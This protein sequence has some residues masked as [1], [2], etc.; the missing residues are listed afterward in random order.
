[1]WNAPP[2]DLMEHLGPLLAR[3][4]GTLALACHHLE[5]GERW[6]LNDIPMPSASLIKVPLAI[7]AYRAA[8]RGE[9]ALNERVEVPPLAAD[10]EADFD[11]LGLA[12]PGTRFSW[13]KI[14]DRMLTESDNAA[15]NTVIARL[16][17]GAIAPLIAELGLEHTV[18]QRPMLDT[19]ARAGGRE[20]ITTPRE[21][22]LLLDGLFAGRLLDA[23][24]TAAM[25]GLLGQQR[26]KDKLARG[27]PADW[28]FAHKTGELSGYRHDAGL[29][30]SPVAGE[31]GWLVAAMAAGDGPVAEAILPLVGTLLAAY[32]TSRR[33]R[34][35]AAT[36]WLDAARDRQAR[37]PRHTWDSLRVEWR[38]GDV[39][40]AG[41]SNWGQAL[42]LAPATILRCDRGP[43]GEAAVASVACLQLRR[44][45]GHAHELVSQLRLGDPLTVL[46]KGPDWTL[47]QGPD[48]Y[49]AYAKTNNMVPAVAWTPTHVVAA[50]L[51][52]IETAAGTTL[53]LSGGTR[54][55]PGAWPGQWR[56]PSGDAIPLA[57]DL[58]TPIGAKGT[59]QAVLAFARQCLG[60]PYLWGGTTGWGIDCSGLVQLAYFVQGVSLPRD[61]DQQQAATEPVADRADLLA[62][63]L[64]FF[65][66]HVGLY[67]G[68]RAYLHASAQAGCVTIG[69]FDPSSPWWDPV[70]DER[71]DGGG[72]SP[73]AIAWA[74]I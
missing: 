67:L 40:V 57:P 68:D 28:P 2:P 53:Q 63:D 43:T 18:L 62:G 50:P 21:M 29:V 26:S 71:Y 11:N 31:R 58:T 1:M 14:I 65:P 46:E 7:A 70:L 4:D 47:V 45:P 73:L 39:I 52:T 44:G 49:V 69:S 30:G 13:H 37:D 38:D 5:T 10:D 6:A 27:L 55:A 15:T 51:V 66:G 72:R 35:E 41:G 25:A 16:G 3:W 60:L 23:S 12:P 48:D 32:F 36:A 56:L 42:G 33:A 20:N 24:D 64:V 9:L 74:V 59:I 22:V 54:L 8:A 17:L 34:Y 19:A 61:A